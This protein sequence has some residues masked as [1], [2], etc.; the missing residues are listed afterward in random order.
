MQIKQEI[1]LL[2]K[3]KQKQNKELYRIHI[4]VY[5]IPAKM[6]GSQNKFSSPPTPFETCGR[7]VA[8]CPAHIC[9]YHSGTFSI[10]EMLSANYTL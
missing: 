8:I 5:R 1:K 2:Y 3:K 6:I 4:E 10:T 7:N 9:H